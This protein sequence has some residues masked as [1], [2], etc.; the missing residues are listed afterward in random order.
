MAVTA[1]ARPGAAAPHAVP[2]ARP[3]LKWVGGKRQLLREL[4]PR[5]PARLDSYYEP[6]LGGGALFFRLAADP[7]L[8][9]RHAVLSDLNPALIA[10]YRAVRDQP[11]ALIAALE[12]VARD[13]LE[14]E[15]AERKLRYYAM[16]ERFRALGAAGAGDLEIA[17]HLLFLNRTGYGGLFR[18]NSRG[19]FNVPFG[20][21]PAPR[22]LDRAGL[23]AAAAALRNVEL[24]CADFQ[25]AC[26]GAGPDSFV[27]GD[28]PYGRGASPSFTAYTS[29]GFNRDDQLRLKCC[30]DAL[31]ARGARVLLS[32]SAHPWVQ[33]LYGDGTYLVE[34]VAA[35]RAINSRVDRRG[36]IQELLV[37]APLACRAGSAVLDQCRAP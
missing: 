14:R 16:R 32:N 24:R 17:T 3:F 9:P 21:Y 4:L 29:T 30:L 18:L 27:Y 10:T 20:N 1:H 25:D 31:V 33:A 19:Q 37:S 36:P 22:I 28:P 23:R 8:R 5:V 7:E 34:Q 35:R 2:G 15:D 12:E 13:Y 11:D 26:A 6:F